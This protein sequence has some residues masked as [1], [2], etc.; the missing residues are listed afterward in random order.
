MK[1][2]FSY[3]GKTLAYEIIHKKV[4]NINIRVKPNGEVVVSCN[5]SIDNKTIELEMIKRANWLLETIDEY[6]T[7]LIEFIDSNLKLVDGEAF[8]VLGKVLRIRNI[9]SDEFYVTWFLYRGDKGLSDLEITTQKLS[10]VFVSEFNPVDK[11]YSAIFETAGEDV[12]G[13]YYAI[14]KNKLNGIESAYNNRPEQ[15]KMFSVTGS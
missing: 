7:N 6:K 15:N 14:V 4:K 13:Y 11:S 8:L 9:K 2:E 3:N 12:E 5:E 10:N 1:Y